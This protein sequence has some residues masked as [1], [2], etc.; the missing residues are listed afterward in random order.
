MQTD[1]MLNVFTLFTDIDLKQ[2]EV[3][4]FRGAMIHVAG[5]DNVDFHDHESEGFRYLYPRVQY[6]IIDHKA[7][8]VFVG[9]G[10]ES[11]GKILSGAGGKIQIGR[12]SAVFNITGMPMSQSLVQVNDISNTYKL[13]RWLP[14]NQ[15]NY[16]LFSSLESLQEKCAFLERLLVGNI[17]SFA[18]G[19]GIFFDSEVEASIVDIEMM[20]KYKFKNVN[21]L[22]FDVVFSTNVS[23]PQYVGLGKGVS[24]GF[25][26]ITN[27]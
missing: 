11:I 4:L 27:K 21:M 23:L 24:L 10:A 12:R 26:M 22:G 25:G 20:G 18:K 5:S 8:V 3:P 9:E 14:L 15:D 7:S 2:E 17:L 6:K 16:E 1:N 19:V 13:S